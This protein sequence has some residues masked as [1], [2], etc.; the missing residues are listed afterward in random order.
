MRVIICDICK[1]Q[2]DGLINC[3]TITIG[4]SIT[5]GYPDEINLCSGC[6]TRLI[7]WIAH[8]ESKEGETP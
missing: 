4:E 2:T 1:K 8:K 7:Q 6:T 3:A 5:I